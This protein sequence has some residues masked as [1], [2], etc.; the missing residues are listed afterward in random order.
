MEHDFTLRNKM[1][2]AK[3]EY[4]KEQGALGYNWDVE[5]V[6]WTLQDYHSSKGSVL[7]FTEDDWKCCKE[8]DFSLYEVLEFCDEAYLENDLLVDYLENCLDD[9][10]RRTGGECADKYI[11]KQDVL[12]YIEDFY[13]WHNDRYLMAQKVYS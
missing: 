8:N 6:V 10:R 2:T 5:G 9:W 13:T 3:A 7:D 4:E 1:A 12:A 11:P